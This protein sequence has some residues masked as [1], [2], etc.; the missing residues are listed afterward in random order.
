MDVI[1]QSHPDI[2]LGSNMF[3]NCPTILQYESEPLLEVGKFE[4]AG[5][6]TR[7]SV[8]HS[9]GTKIAVVKGARIFPTEE[10]KRAKLE[11]R[12][13]PLLTV[14]ELEG[15]PILELR[16]R[17]AAALKGWARLYAPEGVLIKADD[18]QSIAQLRNGKS[19][20]L[21]GGLVMSDSVIDG[22]QIGIHVTSTGMAIGV[23][24][25]SVF[26]GRLGPP[27]S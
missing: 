18:A 25:G 2:M 1:F 3:K 26:I 17:D 6:T 10:G 12:H 24:G 27:T 15:Q 13:E 11:L 14:C 9:D 4:D 5:Y 8:Y 21:L 16:R 23:G 19:L 7:F 22:C 20:L